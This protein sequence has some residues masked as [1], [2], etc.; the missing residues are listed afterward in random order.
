MRIFGGVTGAWVVAALT[1]ALACGKD[2]DGDSSTTGATVASTT[3]GETASEPTG[4][5][6]PA[7]PVGAFCQQ[8]C[9]KDADCWFDGEGS[10]VCGPDKRCANPSYPRCETD[11]ECAPVLNFW[12]EPCTASND[13]ACA[14]NVAGDAKATCLDIGGGE[15]RCAV[16]MNPALPCNDFLGEEQQSWPTV[17]G[18]IVQVCAVAGPPKCSSDRYCFPGCRD[19]SDCARD[20]GSPTPHCGADSVCGCQ[21]DAECSDYHGSGACLMG[22]C[23]CVTDA[24]CAGGEYGEGDRCFAGR[25]GCS[26]AAVCDPDPFPTYDGTIVV[27]EPYPD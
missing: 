2:N 10:S 15:G 19:D 26:D 22:S 13:P 8:A 21:T 12:D 25:C 4:T 24:D 20:T 7:A 5:T 16:L 3:G 11:E 17:E 1:V 9:A 23:G 6:G 14:D 27:C 18:N